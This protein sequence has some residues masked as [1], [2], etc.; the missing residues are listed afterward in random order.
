MATILSGINN[1]GQIIGT[2]LHHRPGSSDINDYD[3]ENAF[4]YDNG[5]FTELN[6]PGAQ[7]PFCCGAQT[8]PMDINNVGQIVGSTYSPEGN[9]QFFLLKD[10]NFLRITGLPENVV[11]VDGSWGLN[12]K[13]HIAGTYVQKLPCDTCGILGDAGYKFTVHNFVAKPQKP[14]KKRLLN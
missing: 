14:S 10:G 8:F 5:N 2:Y 6:F 12:D 9:L 4:T 1:A 7:I 3:S 13:G 11:G